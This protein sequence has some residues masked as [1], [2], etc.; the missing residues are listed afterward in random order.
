MARVTIEDCVTRVP[1]RFELVL[2]A[3]QRSRA[4]SAGG[5]ITV[6][7]DNDKNSVV[8]LREIADG[9]VGL[10]ELRQNLL[11]GLQKHVE[12]DQPEEEDSMAALMQ[13]GTWPPMAA[14]AE[15]LPGMQLAEVETAEEADESAD[16]SADEE[17]VDGDEASIGEA[18]DTGETAPKPEE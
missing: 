13:Q 5:P 8:A 1:N 9:G 15:S 12:T 11:I 4:I 7:R 10:D 3:A 6:E 14:D 16:E 17:A 18:D 2:L